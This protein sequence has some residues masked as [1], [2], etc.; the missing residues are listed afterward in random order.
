MI[1]GE[2]AY[3]FLTDETIVL[4]GKQVFYG[5]LFRKCHFRMEPDAQPTFLMCVLD[6]ECTFDP[7][8]VIDDLGSWPW[9]RC[10]SNQTH[11][12]TEKT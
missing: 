6:D 2:G 4:T 9:L 3:R 8:F 1:K 5:D 10:N 11:I 12:P 7:P